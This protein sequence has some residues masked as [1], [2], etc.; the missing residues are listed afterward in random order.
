[1]TTDNTA[2]DPDAKA[3]WELPAHSVR[4]LQPGDVIIRSGC[5]DQVAD[6][7]VS[8]ITGAKTV[9]FTDGPDMRVTDAVYDHVDVTICRP[10]PGF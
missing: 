8:R 9:Q 2:H 10:R 4:C 6:V 3:L 5:L 7:Q 1:M